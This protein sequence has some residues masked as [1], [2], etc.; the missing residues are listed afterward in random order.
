MT[1]WDGLLGADGFPVDA[2]APRV[3]LLDASSSLAVDEFAS[4]FVAKR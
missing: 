1:Y 2:I 3:R 4:P